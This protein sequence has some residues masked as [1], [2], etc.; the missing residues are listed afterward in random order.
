MK[1]YS[2]FLFFMLLSSVSYSTPT[3]QNKEKNNSPDR[4]PPIPRLVNLSEGGVRLILPRSDELPTLCIFKFKGT[5]EARWSCCDKP[6]E[7]YS[8]KFHHYDILACDPLGEGDD[9]TT[10]FS[11]TVNKNEKNQNKKV[12]LTLSGDDCG[13]VLLEGATFLAKAN[14]SSRRV[15]VVRPYERYGNVSEIKDWLGYNAIGY[16]DTYVTTEEDEI[17]VYNFKYENIPGETDLQTTKIIDLPG[18]IKELI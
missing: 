13:V 8:C 3:P 10:K 16:P 7:T 1:T 17:S 4:Y 15:Y 14:D 18:D 11:L 9:R 5:V 6:G 12:E 2:V